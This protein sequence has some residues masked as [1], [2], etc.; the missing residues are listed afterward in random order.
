MVTHMEKQLVLFGVIL[1]LGFLPFGATASMEDP[2]VLDPGGIVFVGFVERGEEATG[3]AMEASGDVIGWI[4]WRGVE[5]P[6]AGGGAEMEPESSGAGGGEFSAT[7]FGS[8]A[9]ILLTDREL[10]V[11]A[12]ARVPGSEVET[13]VSISFEA[14]I[15]P[16]LPESG[17]QYEWDFDGDGRFD[18]LSE[19]ASVIHAYP[20]SGVY[21]VQVRVLAVEGGSMVSEPFAV[22]V[23]NRT[24]VAAFDAM[25]DPASESVTLLDLSSDLD[26]TVIAWE[27]DFG[28][29]QVSTEAQPIHQYTYPG[30]Y[31]VSLVAID[32]RGA[33]SVPTSQVVTIGNVPPV[34]AFE[35]GG[36]GASHS[37]TFVDLSVDPSSEG[38]VVHV[39]W[40][41]GDDTYSAGGPATDGVYQHS[42]AAPGLY[43]VT[44]YVIDNHGGLSVVSEQ[45]LVPNGA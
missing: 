43:V 20:R 12:L 24:P 40:D 8:D 41:F 19:E 10:T 28:D 39:G 32:D 1:A 6:E 36:V 15:D 29:G 5:D 22:S 3:M 26:G 35:V 34:A 2:A 11:T 7:V 23:A 18:A 31:T 30:E 27:W 45:V 21:F 25:T 38:F 13:F 16:A 44:L 14:V 9:G 42:Y 33:R 4:G 17:L 37:V